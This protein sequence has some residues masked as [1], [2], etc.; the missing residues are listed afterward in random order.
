MGTE[1]AQFG[2]PFVRGKLLKAIHELDEVLGTSIDNIDSD[3]RIG[4]NEIVQLN[5]LIINVE[6]L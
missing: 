1:N 2:S 6:L 3:L 5:N 4:P